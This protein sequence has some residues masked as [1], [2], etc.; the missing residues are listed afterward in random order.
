[1]RKIDTRTRKKRR[2]VNWAI[3]GGLV[4]IFP[5]GNM[6]ILGSYQRGWPTLTGKVVE[7]KHHGLKRTVTYRYKVMGRVIEKQQT[8][9]DISLWDYINNTV[10]NFKEGDLVQVHHHPQNV[11]ISVLNPGYLAHLN[12]TRN[13][14]IVVQD[15]YE[16]IESTSEQM[17]PRPKV[18]PTL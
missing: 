13:K 6:W 5:V 15:P 2:L 10:P 8:S 9:W 7:I 14:G 16:N 17:P 4:S 11:A 12:F 1:L 3:L 18:H